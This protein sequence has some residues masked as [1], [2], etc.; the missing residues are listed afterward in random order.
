MSVR[1]VIH[2]LAYK[3]QDTACE[4]KKEKWNST[5]AEEE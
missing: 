1:E 2:G 4:R 3:E 5:D